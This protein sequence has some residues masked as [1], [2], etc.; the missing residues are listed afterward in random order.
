MGTANLIRRGRTNATVS[1]LSK[2]N[3]DCI[4]DGLMDEIVRRLYVEVDSGAFSDIVRSESAP[5]DTTKIW[6]QPSSKLAFAFD[7]LSNSWEETNISGDTRLSSVV[8]NLIRM[9]E[10]GAI[11]TIISASERN[12]LTVD[13]EGNILLER[14]IAPER[15]ESSVTSD[16]SGDG[17][18][19]V[20]FTRFSDKLAAISVMPLED[21]G[22]NARWWV[23]EQ[24]DITAKIKFAGLA[25][26][27][28]FS[29]AIVGTP[30]TE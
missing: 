14:G 5:T 30:T 18:T 23:D 11:F 19:T 27:S 7:T 24:T 22:E 3:G 10:S 13:E 12:L 17:E 8:N 26:A 20:T 25:A 2:V 29:I 4:D 21:L 9:D 6:Y 16:G 28:T 1:R 15:I